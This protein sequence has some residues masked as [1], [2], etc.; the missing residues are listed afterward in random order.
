MVYILDEARRD[1]IVEKVRTAFT[2]ARGV[3]KVVGPEGMKDYG[4]AN[5]KDDPHAPDMF[6][7][8][9]LG[10]SFGDTSAGSIPFVEKPEVSGTHGHGPNPPDLHATFVAWGKGIKPGVSLGE[11]TNLEVAPT[12]AELLKL[13]LPNTDGKPLTA[14]LAK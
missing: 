7:F 5:P 14:I 6:L 2:G 12:I 3:S 8:A 4:I 13:S 11:I 10:T 1:E 9:E